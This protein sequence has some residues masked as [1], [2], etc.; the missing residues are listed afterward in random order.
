MFF[1]AV[2]IV[3]A[4]PVLDRTDPWWA[5]T[6]R[7]VGG[8]VVLGVHAAIRHRRETLRV[9]RPGR[10]WKLLVPTGA[11][12]TYFAMFFWIAGMK[13]THTTVASVLNQTSAIHVLVLATVFLREPLTLRKLVAILL[14][15]AGGVVAAF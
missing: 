7:L 4:K 11:M 1:M 9:L 2:G 5:T 14:G 12:G 15:F 13:Y 10:H 8:V 3:M 6:V